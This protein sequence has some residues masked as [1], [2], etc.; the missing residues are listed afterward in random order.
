MLGALLI[1]TERS[2]KTIDFAPID[3]LLLFGATGLDAISVM[4]QTIAF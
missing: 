2:L 1:S 3:D 4:S